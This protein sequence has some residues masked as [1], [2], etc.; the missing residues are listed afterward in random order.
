MTGIPARRDRFLR[1]GATRRGSELALV[2]E[3]KFDTRAAAV[4]SL[5][6]PCGEEAP[7]SSAG[8]RSF[9]A[10]LGV[11]RSHA[12][13]SSHRPWALPS[14]STPDPWS[15]RTTSNGPPISNIGREYSK[16]RVGCAQPR[17][18]PE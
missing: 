15:A 8:G 3:L 12:A 13:T 16:L 14:R 5:Q 10:T 7:R 9:T 11:G 2:A 4:G 6:A 18:W 1:V 17:T